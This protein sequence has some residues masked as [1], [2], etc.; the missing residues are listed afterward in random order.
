M[1]GLI[2][3]TFINDLIESADIVEII[4]SRLELKK[5][6]RNF[7]GLCPFHNEKTPSFS[8]SPE[9]QFFHCFGCKESGTILTFLMKYENLDF[10]EAIEALAKHVGRDVPREMGKRDSAPEQTKELHALE[11]AVQIFKDNLRNSSEAI[12]YLKRRGISGEIARDFGLG[13]APDEWQHLSSKLEKDGFS[14]QVLLNS[15]LT[16]TNDRGRH[17]DR[18]RGRIT[19][20]IRNIRGKTIGF[21]GRVFR[22]GTPKYL[23]SP[24]TKLFSKSKEVYGLFEA[25][26]GNQRLDRLILVEGYMDVIALAQHGIRNVV[27]TLG[28]AVGE[29]HLRKMYR[30]SREIV[31]CFDGDEAGRSAAFRALEAA[32]PFLDEKKRI[33]F[34]FLP[35]GED[36]DSFV[37][38][39]GSDRFLELVQSSTPGFEYLF[40]SLG[41]NL[42]LSL[43][44]DKVALAGLA[45]PLIDRVNSKLARDVLLARLGELTGLDLSKP[46]SRGASKPIQV[47]RDFSQPVQK[48]SERL[49][50]MLVRRP[51]LL[52]VLSIEDRDA[53]AALGNESD[54]FFKVET[55]ISRDPNL[56]P[57]ELISRWPDAEDVDKVVALANF[58]EVLGVDEQEIQ[59]LEGVGRWL[60]LREANAEVE[61][62]KKHIN[63]RGEEGTVNN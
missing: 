26:K 5:A 36:P 15:G 62:L 42:D 46:Q 35:N 55:I 4:G 9:K 13:Y 18:F 19:F 11:S 50:G 24:E 41:S 61:R 63:D 27:A 49:A 8:V 6:G 30:Y 38:R 28:T 51:E 59:F 47:R 48:L 31:C 56:L 54:L 52:K 22:D 25:R 40:S 43:L 34:I 57:E 37:N 20:P 45:R 10:V 12:S 33:H 7:Q 44:D 3:Q 21:G 60:G 14:A 17:Y 29:D 16:T 2:P 32:L 53:L 58:E 1:S 39:N 23:N